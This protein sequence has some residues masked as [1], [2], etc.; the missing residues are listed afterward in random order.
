MSVGIGTGRFHF[1]M[2][3]SVHRELL[4]AGPAVTETLVMEGI[5]DAGEIGLS[6]TLA[7]R[8]DPACI[9]PN[10]GGARL[11]AAPPDADRERARRRR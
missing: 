9:G 3:G 4:L 2:T 1:F 11:L 5:A 6:P 7:M 8:L 10:K